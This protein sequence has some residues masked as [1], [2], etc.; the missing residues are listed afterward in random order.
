[1]GIQAPRAADS[2]AASG[3]VH[4]M[5]AEFELPVDLH[6]VAAARY[7]NT[8]CTNG[9][10]ITTATLSCRKGTGDGRS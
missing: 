8:I 3:R 10:I 1:M 4:L 6:F 7:F 2:I 9:I 5:E